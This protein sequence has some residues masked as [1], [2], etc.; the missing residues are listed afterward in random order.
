[1]I[2]PDLRGARAI[3]DYLGM[4]RRTMWRYAARPA[5][6]LPLLDLL[7]AVV[8]RRTDLDAWLGR[9][10]RART[11]PQPPATEAPRRRIVDVEPTEPRRKPR[12]T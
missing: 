5:D 6:P 8:A 1:M 4:G 7:G 9:Q 2:R 12:H 3:A 10:L 11:A